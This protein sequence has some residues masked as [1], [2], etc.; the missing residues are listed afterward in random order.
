MNHRLWRHLGQ[1]GT[2]ASIQ[3]G[4]ADQNPA[5][6]QLSAACLDHQPQ[7]GGR[8]IKHLN[9][10]RRQSGPL[11]IRAQIVQ[12]MHVGPQTQSLHRPIKRQRM[13]QPAQD[14]DTHARPDAK[15]L[16]IHRK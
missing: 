14:R 5:Q 9:P 11:P 16:R 12:K 13:H 6:G 2:Q 1:S 10:P 8:G 3:F 4:A 7:L 15:Q